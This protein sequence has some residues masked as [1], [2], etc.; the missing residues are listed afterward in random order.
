MS[1]AARSRQQK[2]Q[3]QA[4][5][6]EARRRLLCKQLTLTAARRILHSI[7]WYSCHLAQA[8]NLTC[9][10]NRA[11]ILA[12]ARPSHRRLAQC[13]CHRCTTQAIFDRLA[14]PLICLCVRLICCL[15]VAN[16]DHFRS[17][18]RASFFCDARTIFAR[19][20]RT[21]CASRAC[22]FHF[23]MV[24]GR[25]SRNRHLFLAIHRSACALVNACSAT[26]APA[27]TRPASCCAATS[28]LVTSDNAC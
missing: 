2:S 12:A 6:A 15:K 22:T 25:I 24:T 4:R 5:R 21:R 13:L 8:Q 19:D 10:R 11:V 28:S 27:V 1:R 3:R 16:S 14:C 20:R 18:A 26:T 7:L 23:S 17:A 9:R